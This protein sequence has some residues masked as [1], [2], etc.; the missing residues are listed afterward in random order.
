MNT[1]IDQL[2]LNYRINRIIV[3]EY[4]AHK[5]HRSPLCVLDLLDINPR[6]ITKFRSFGKESL[7]TLRIALKK[8]CDEN[9]LDVN[10]FEIFQ[11]EN[12]RSC[13]TFK[14]V[15]N[16]CLRIEEKLDAL[17]MKGEK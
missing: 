11:E 2:G 9:Q 5:P 1:D 17:L 6:E 14:N 10:D 16:I 8:F 15:Y 7:R 3:N 4:F 12:P 13:V